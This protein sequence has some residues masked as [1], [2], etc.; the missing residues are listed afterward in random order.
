VSAERILEMMRRRQ[1]DARTELSFSTERLTK[2]FGAEP[3]GI[4]RALRQI[5]RDR[6]ILR[7]DMTG[8]WILTGKPLLKR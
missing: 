2:L 7:D 8:R 3:A 5:E 4:F 6:L 1:A